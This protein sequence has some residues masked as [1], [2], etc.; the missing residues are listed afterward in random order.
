[1]TR[2]LVWAFIAYAI[3]AAL[4]GWTL[5]DAAIRVGNRSV[6]LRVAVWIMLGGFAMKTLIA[7][8]RFRAEEGEDRD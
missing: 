5:G 3:L 2:R 1:M 4:A 7:Y 8:G 6:E